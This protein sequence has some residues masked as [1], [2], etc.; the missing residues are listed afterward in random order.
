MV[1]VNLL[2][3]DNPGYIAQNRGTNPFLSSFPIALRTLLYLQAQKH[4]SGG[5]ERTFPL[6]HSSNIGLQAT[7]HRIY[8]SRGQV[9]NSKLNDPADSPCVQPQSNHLHLPLLR[10][11]VTD[12][13]TNIP[14]DIHVNRKLVISWT[15]RMICLHCI[16]AEDWGG[17]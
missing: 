1:V 12:L 15:L 2:R 7:S 17:L 14:M 9:E 10:R 13:Q 4:I 6:T 5:K 11:E 3:T 8:A 16:R